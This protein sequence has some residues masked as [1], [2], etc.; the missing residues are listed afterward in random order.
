MI[1]LTRLTLCSGHTGTFMMIVLQ[2]GLAM[3]PTCLAM[4]SGL[5][6]GTTS[7]MPSLRRKALL[8]STTTAPAA[9]AAGAYSLEMPPPALN[10]AICTPAKLSRV[11][12]STASVCPA[13]VIVLPALRPLASSFNRFRWG[14][15]ARPAR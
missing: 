7:G 2:L 15:S 8:L 1:R 11:S 4:A 13:K 12:S 6:S 3:M 5:T 10:S 14:T 9:T